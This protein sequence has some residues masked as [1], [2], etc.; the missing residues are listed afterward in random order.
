MGTWERPV[1]ETRDEEARL[2]VSGIEQVMKA[3]R[4]AYPELSPAMIRRILRLPP[5]SPGPA[6]PPEEGAA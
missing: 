2:S 5:V 4:A 1:K 6:V 3:L